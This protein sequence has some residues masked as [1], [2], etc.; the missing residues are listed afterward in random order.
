MLLRAPRYYED[1]ERRASPADESEPVQEYD[2]GDE[3]QALVQRMSAL[4]LADEEE[5]R[6]QDE[7][8]KARDQ[9]EDQDEDQGE[10]DQD[11][12]EDQGEEEEDEEEDQGEEEEGQDEEEDQG[13]EEEGQDQDEDQGEEE[14]GQEEEDEEEDQGEEEEDEE[15]DEEAARR[16][17]AAKEAERRKEIANANK[18]KAAKRLARLAEE[19]AE[20]LAKEGKT[21]R[22]RTPK[23]RAESE[24]EVEVDEGLLEEYK[25]VL[26]IVG[27]GKSPKLA[28]PLTV[29]GACVRGV[30]E[31][32][33]N[34]EVRRALVERL[35][36]RTRLSAVAAISASHMIINKAVYRAKYDEEGE[37]V[38]DYLLRQL[39]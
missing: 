10:E 7:D 29:Q 21:P 33:K 5:A 34:F 9:G 8:E 4:S 28:E 19:K 18:R 3:P 35:M 30:G 26:N 6:D 14:E 38:I 20:K 39:E 11:E 37:Q 31:L 2:F 16:S 13:E 27:V 12:E 15:E 25:Y 32:E 1:Q 24:E 23:A 22:A 17:A 36:A